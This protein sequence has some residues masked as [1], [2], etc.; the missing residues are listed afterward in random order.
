LE[1]G[2]CTSQEQGAILLVV[3]C[4]H[5]LHSAFKQTSL[6]QESN[7]IL[8]INSQPADVIQW[9]YVPTAS[10]G[11]SG[12]VFDNSTIQ[13]VES[14]RNAIGSNYSK[15]LFE[16]YST[17]SFDERI[18]HSVDQQ[19]LGLLGP[20]IHA[21]VGDTVVI[22]FRNNAPIPLS[23][24]PHGLN[25]SWEMQGVMYGNSSGGSSGEGAYVQPGEVFRYVWQV[26][27]SAGPGDGDFSSVIW[28]YYSHVDTDRDINSG[29]IGAI[30]VTRA[31]AIAS[32]AS[33]D[34]GVP[35]DV[36]REFILFASVLDENQSHLLNESV[37]IAG[38]SHNASSDR[39]MELNR[40][41]SINGH[42]FGQVNGLW[43]QMYERVRWYVLTSGAGEDQISLHW[44]GN[45][46]VSSIGERVSTV[47]LIPSTWTVLDMI[48]QQPGIFLIDS[49]YAI[50]MEAL[51]TV[52]GTGSPTST[53]APTNGYVPR[54]R[55]YFIQAEFANWTY[56]SSDVDLVT[57]S[58]MGEPR[59][60]ME[61]A[62]YVFFFFFK[63]KF[64][65]IT[66]SIQCDTHFLACTGGCFGIT[67]QQHVPQDPLR[68]IFQQ[69]V[70]SPCQSHQ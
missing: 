47:G 58:W 4:E 62:V 59:V 21:V 61:E 65:K 25:V 13:Y 14:G 16:E 69:F 36:D 44:H 5:I 26:P 46:L 53:P 33:A 32:N 31:D 27:E 29:L 19:Y 63:F 6:V 9:D 40:R 67:D 55:T 11:I 50:G 66:V 54:N 48:P 34:H 12:A 8:T 17:S 1:S 3:S 49:S 24:Q 52:N 20:V 37:Q 68:R 35:S 51:Y 2:L 22:V 18:Y 45:T 41:G 23:I 30:I 7:K 39:F 64:F 70:P 38:V 28:S 42:M 15:I 60:S 57:G 43:C 56:A 10:D